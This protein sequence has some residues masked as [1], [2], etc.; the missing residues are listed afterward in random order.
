MAKSGIFQSDAGAVL[1]S[2]A[3]EGLRRQIVEFLSHCGLRVLEAGAGHET[4]QAPE[5]SCSIGL[6]I[7]DAR[8]HEA[9]KLVREAARHH[10]DIQLLVI[11]G[12]P[13][14]IN[15]ELVPDP[16]IHFIEKPF[17][18]CELGDEV[19]GILGVAAFAAQQQRC[20]EARAARAA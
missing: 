7:A 10:P 20:T 12:D 15:R 3:A 11:S 4:P 18:W 5:Q 16:C 8:V 13:P 14:W 19:A 2:I 1:V 17:S 9:P 6:L